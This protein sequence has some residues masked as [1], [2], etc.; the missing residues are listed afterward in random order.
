MDNFIKLERLGE[1]TYGTVFK[2]RN[3]TT[4]DLSALKQIKLQGEEDEG[5]PISAVREI[6]FLR[7]LQ[8]QNVVKLK[9]VIPKDG[10]LFLLF[11]LMKQDL[12]QFIN[13]KVAEEGSIA[14]ATIQHYT[15]QILQG[16]DYCHKRRLIHRDLKPQNILLSESGGSG[17]LKLG[18]FGLA[19]L[20][21]TPTRVSTFE[22]STLWYRAPELLLE[23][24][25]YSSGVDIWSLGCVL[26]EMVRGTPIFKGMNEV[27]QLRSI[28]RI[29]GTPRE[30][31]W[32]GVSQSSVYQEIS[33]SV[34]HE[35]SL[36][37]ELRTSFP[38]LLDLSSK[39]F[40]LNPK[41]RITAEE[42]LKHPYFVGVE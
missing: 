21:G 12:R 9:D 19:R 3:K 42:G 39:L 20:I 22:I 40:A 10:R 30:S 4:G 6:S 34:S 27:D 2:V 25:D 15:C 32:P 16:L 36:E 18:D 38:F 29:L 7:T 37:Q 24:G 14:P 17:G 26:A 1:G 13:S 23:F 8:H 33:Y 5:I 31:I 41:H 11:E 28:F 35:S